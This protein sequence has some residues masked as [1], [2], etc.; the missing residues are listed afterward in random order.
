MA[1]A[2]NEKRFLQQQLQL[3]SKQAD[4]ADTP[5]GNVSPETSAREFY[6]SEN[7]VFSPFSPDIRTGNTRINT[8]KTRG[9]AESNPKNR[10]NPAGNQDTPSDSWHTENP[11]LQTNGYRIPK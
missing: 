3:H 9:T 6:V 8:E 11:A 4:A 2:M 5:K 1:P 7:P 10:K